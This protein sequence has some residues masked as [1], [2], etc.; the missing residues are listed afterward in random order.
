MSSDGVPVVTRST[1]AYAGYGAMPALGITI[2]EAGANGHVKNDCVDV[3]DTEPVPVTSA[4]PPVGV[5]V[6]SAAHRSQNTVAVPY[7][8]LAANDT[9]ASVK[10]YVGFVA[11]TAAAH[12][13]VDIAYLAVAVTPAAARMPPGAVV[14]STST[15]VELSI[16]GCGVES[17]VGVKEGV[18]EAD[19]EFDLVPD[20]E[21]VFDIV[22]ELLG[23]RENVGVGVWL[24]V[25]PELGVCVP[26][27]VGLGDGCT[28]PAT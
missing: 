9:F 10:P 17:G 3:T 7:D 26:D 4:A 25:A 15:T 18:G 21:G 8:V 1:I 27:G 6:A 19:G 14:V 16:C 20:P 11:I 5:Y 22:P 24:V 13:V 28:T 23:D 12:A 2:D